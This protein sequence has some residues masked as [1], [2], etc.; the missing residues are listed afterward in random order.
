M[1][2][3]T[4]AFLSPGPGQQLPGWFFPLQLVLIAGIFWFLLL[5][6]QRQQQKQHEDMLKALKRGDEVITAGGIVGTV[7]HIKEERVTIQ[8]A[9]SRLVVERARITKVVAPQ[10]AEEAAAK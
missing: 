1:H 3:L 4:F 10:K 5:R 7:I 9:E 2:P 6:P 8:S